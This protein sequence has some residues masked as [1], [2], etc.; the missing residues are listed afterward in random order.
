MT[1]TAREDIFDA[2]RVYNFAFPHRRY[3][4]HL[5]VNIVEDIITCM[6]MMQKYMYVCVVWNG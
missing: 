4:T 5:S 6:Y 2:L 3:Y 1:M